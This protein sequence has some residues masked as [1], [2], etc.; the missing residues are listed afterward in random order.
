MHRIYINNQIDIV[1]NLKPNVVFLVIDSFRS[2][3]CVGDTK[4]SI[5][6]N[7]D[8]IIKNGTYFTQAISSGSQTIPSV[9]SLFT[10]LYPLK[11]VSEKESHFTINVNAP[12]YL[13]IIKNSG[14]NI[15]AIVADHFP[16]LGLSEVFED[17][18]ITFDPQSTVYDGVGEKIRKFLQTKK[19]QPWFV[20]IHLLDLHGSAKFQLSKGPTEF[21]DKKFGKNQYERM[22]SCLDKWVGKILK[23]IDLENTLVIV[24]ADHGSEDGVF[25][26]AMEIQKQKIRIVEPSKIQKSLSKIGKISPS[27]LTPVKGK[28]RERNLKK[29]K[30]IVEERQEDELKKIESLDVSAYQKRIMKHN[31]RPIV[32][33]YD[34]RFRIPLIFSGPK[35][36]K[37]IKISQLV[38]MVDIF[39]TIME[40]VGINVDSITSHGKSILPLLEGKEIPEEPALIQ[41]L[42]NWQRSNSANVIGVR[43]SKYKYFRDVNNKE[44]NIHIFD[45][46]NDPLEEKNI[47]SENSEI[48]KFEKYITNIENTHIETNEKGRIKKRIG[49]KLKKLNLKE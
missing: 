40:L 24:T 12:N 35:I 38:R 16:I 7:I 31:V 45:L 25:D 43:T 19:T 39:P 4:S 32:H 36:R 6:P 23:D 42:T 37:N 44:K 9:A 49:L 21:Y 27:F 28:I 8:S 15:H 26:E 1:H 47:Y 14:Y 11:A 22:V 17:N 2:D 20:Y 13:N 33:V 29:R 10:G 41:S 46:I 30:N 5:T 3:K 34:D 18:I 48:K